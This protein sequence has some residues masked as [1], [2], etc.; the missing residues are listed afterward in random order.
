MRPAGAT[1][2]A[3]GPA[4]S[5]SIRML[6]LIDL[7]LVIVRKSPWATTTFCF[8]VSSMSPNVLAAILARPKCFSTQK[9]VTLPCIVS[10]VSVHSPLPHPASMTTG[11]HPPSPAG[12][13]ARK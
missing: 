5:V 6:H 11:G 7:A 1:P 9:M 12:S 10:I 3:A 2:G 4:K 8:L 13:F